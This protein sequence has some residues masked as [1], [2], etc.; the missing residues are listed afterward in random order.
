MITPLLQKQI[1]NELNWLFREEI[2]TE[3]LRHFFSDVLVD[4]DINEYSSINMFLAM[5]SESVYVQLQWIDNDGNSDCKEYKVPY[6][7]YNNWCRGMMKN[8]R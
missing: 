6:E 3:F 1:S 2:T 7:A 5:S 4:E 8:E